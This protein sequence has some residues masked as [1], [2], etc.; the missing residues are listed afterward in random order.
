VQDT[1]DG[2]WFS[3]G[4]GKVGAER[5]KARV[6][7]NAGAILVVFLLALSA[8]C[9]T[10]GD[11]PGGIEAGKGTPNGDRVFLTVDF[12][13]G[14]TLRYRFVSNR[15][16]A[17]DWDPNA[18]ASQ[19]RVQKQVEQ[20]E[21][22]VA[23]TALEVDPYGVST[24]QA[25]CESIEA[26][27]A[28]GPAQRTVA[29]DAVQSA[30]GKTFTFK[31]DSRGKIVDAAEL[32]AFIKKMGAKAFRA[33][34]SRGRVKE[35]DMIGDFTASQWFLWD[36]V[37]SVELPAE[38][39]GVGQ[40]WV[41]KLLVPTPMVIRQAR[42]VTYT[43]KEIRAGDAAAVAVIESAYSAADAV[44][45][46]WPVPYAGRFQ[47]SGTFGFL[48]GYQ[49]LALQG[50]GQELFDIDAGRVLKRAQMYRMEMRASLPP[51]GIRANPHL[52][53]DQSLTMELLNP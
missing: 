28:G 21:M 53:I 11:D 45:A 17:L 32:E 10:T 1:N 7:R 41:S 19:N 22:V 40:S 35:P 42:N 20:L 48:G 38:G 13:Q 6:L 8:G 52:T 50:S 43:L 33:D 37:S 34:S 16:I 49:V 24:V 46:A 3:T 39:V 14:Q 2:S 25:T 5:V 44:P 9:R 26:R 29:N 36:S 12:Q 18:A 4:D 31:V 27:R 47:M 30:R 51:M 15:E 23:Y